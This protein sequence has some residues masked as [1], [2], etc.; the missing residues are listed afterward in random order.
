MA[1][2]SDVM[3]SQSPLGISGSP[4]D[5]A[6]CMLFLAADTSRFVTGQVIRP[7]GGVYMA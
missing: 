6:W 7:N 1:R 3:A 4:E 2:C 5:I